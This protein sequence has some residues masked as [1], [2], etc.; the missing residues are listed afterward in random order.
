[1]HP[2]L[3]LLVLDVVSDL[4]GTLAHL[5]MHRCRLLRAYHLVH[6]QRTSTFHNH[7]VDLAIMMA[8]KLG[9]P[10][11]LM[12]LPSTFLLWCFLFWTM[13]VSMA[14]HTAAPWG[15]WVSLCWAVPC[16]LRLSPKH[17]L[18]HHRDPSRHYGESWAM[19][20]W[21]LVAWEQHKSNG[22]PR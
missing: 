15:Y 19:W 17:H 11:A 22:N 1:M 20:D 5:G 9:V 3:H 14:H 21:L 12:P 13:L 2:I 6:H 18:V 16:G 10:L 8:A 7:P 4:C